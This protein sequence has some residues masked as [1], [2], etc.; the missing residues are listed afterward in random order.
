MITQLHKMS[1]TIFPFGRCVNNSPSGFLSGLIYSPLDIS[2]NMTV[3]PGA[4]PF[5]LL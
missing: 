3:C 2:I 4:L 5:H 1:E